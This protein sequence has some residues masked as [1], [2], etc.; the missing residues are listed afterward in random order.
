VPVSL[1]LFDLRG[2]KVADLIQNQPMNSGQH[3]LSLEGL[4][5]ASGI[6]LYR[7]TA[8]KVILSKKMLF[9]K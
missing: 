5:L 6:Y 1:A 4:D 8:G 3:Y 9:L 2:R 7:M